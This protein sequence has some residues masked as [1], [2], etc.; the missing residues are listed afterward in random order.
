M[1]LPKYYNFL[2]L[3]LSELF[4]ERDVINPKSAIRTNQTMVVSVYSEKDFIDKQLE[5]YHWC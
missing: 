3:L 2:N 5:G 1:K 4:S